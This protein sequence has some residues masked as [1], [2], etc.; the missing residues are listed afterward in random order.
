MRMPVEYDIIRAVAPFGVTPNGVIP[1]RAIAD[2][3]GEFTAKSPTVLAIC[4]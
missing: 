1:N 2:G 4:H 3:V